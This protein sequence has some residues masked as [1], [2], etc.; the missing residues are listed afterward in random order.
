MQDEKQYITIEGK[1]IELVSD[2]EYGNLYMKQKI[3]NSVIYIPYTF[4]VDDSEPPDIKE[5]F[6]TY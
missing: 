4:E 2:E 1:C 3:G 5:Y 6:T